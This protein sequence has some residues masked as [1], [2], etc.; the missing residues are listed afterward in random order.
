MVSKYR[1]ILEPA[2]SNPEVDPSKK[3]SSQGMVAG[4][5]G[6]SLGGGFF[7]LLRGDDVVVVAAAAADDDDDDDDD[8]CVVLFDSAS[9]IL[10]PCPC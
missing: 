9:N 7:D 4:E 10:C 6:H 5:G 3:R 2:I 1:D 8:C